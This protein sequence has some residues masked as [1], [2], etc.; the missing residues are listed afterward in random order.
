MLRY[1]TKAL[2]FCIVFFSILSAHVVANDHDK[3]IKNTIW[4]TTL[5]VGVDLAKTCFGWYQKT[6][7]A[8]EINGSID[9]NR[10]LLDADYGLGQIKRDCFR[11][12]G[13]S[14]TYTDGHYFR[15][16][17]SYN[18]LTPTFPY[19]PYNQFFIGLRYA[20]SYFN[21][22]LKSERLQCQHSADDP[23]TKDQCVLAFR[24]IGDFGIADWWEIVV[25]GKVRLTGIIAI[26]CTARYKFSKKMKC[27]LSSLPFD[28]PG[29]GLGEDEYAFGYSLYIL[30]QIPLRKRN[31]TVSNKV[32]T[33]S[34]KE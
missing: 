23:C 24:N 18:F 22:R 6:G 12:Q 8:Y 33:V 7:Q 30:A 3:A 10:L 2:P 17:L 9:F 29:F 11:Q 26:G 27:K 19:F 4:P 5:Y 21:F 14:F 28:I 20:K 1:F 16:G 31:K 13:G 25:G 15:V 32:A 34:I